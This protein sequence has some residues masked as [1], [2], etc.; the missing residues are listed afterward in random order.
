[1]KKLILVVAL[2]ALLLGGFSVVK[3]YL[4]NVNGV[5]VSK[6][7]WYN[8]DMNLG[9]SEE[10]GYYTIVSR[11]EDYTP[12]QRAERNMGDDYVGRI[13]HLSDETVEA[14]M[15]GELDV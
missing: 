14:I 10:F 8:E 4:P 6:V 3:D 13:T 12:E 1:M 15:N 9:Y 2:I 7:A 5:D 11:A